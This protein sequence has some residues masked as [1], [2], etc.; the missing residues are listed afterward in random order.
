VL[1]GNP[2]TKASR[3]RPGRFFFNFSTLQ[4][5][6]SIPPECVFGP[7]AVFSS[8]RCRGARHRQDEFETTPAQQVQAAEYPLRHCRPL[9]CD[10]RRKTRTASGGYGSGR[11]FLRRHRSTLV[12]GNNHR[13]GFHSA[14]FRHHHHPFRRIG[15]PRQRILPVGNQRK[16]NLPDRGF[17]RSLAA[18]FD[19]RASEPPCGGPK[20][21]PF[22]HRVGL[23]GIFLL[24]PAVLGVST[25]RNAAYCFGFGSN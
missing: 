20:H 2:P 13:L 12:Q 4:E 11:L 1:P 24:G 6:I 21:R 16:P 3:S 15:Q 10:C 5:R 22:W 9:R 17:K 18:G 8:E 23:N 14:K 19:G 25:A 7:S